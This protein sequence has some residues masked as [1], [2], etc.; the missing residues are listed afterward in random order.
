MMSLPSGNG[1]KEKEKE[2]NFCCFVF[3]GVFQSQKKRINQAK[4][5]SKVMDSPLFVLMQCTFSLLLVACMPPPTPIMCSHLKY[6]FTTLYSLLFQSSSSLNLN[7]YV[8]TLK[9]KWRDQNIIDLVAFFLEKKCIK[10]Y[11]EREE[12]WKYTRNIL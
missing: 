11:I 4:V 8:S 12:H 9:A 7:H 10:L 3:I 6:H 5:E 2:S 1:E